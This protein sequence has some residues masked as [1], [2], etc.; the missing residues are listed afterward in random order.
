MANLITQVPIPNTPMVDQ[1]TGVP[2][3][4]WFDF[5]TTIWLRTGG[6]TADAS[7][8]LDNLGSVRGGMLARFATAWAEFEATVANTI[9]VMNPGGGTDVQLKTISQLLNLLG[10]PDAGKI[11]TGHGAADPSWANNVAITPDDFGAVGNG[12]TDDTIA[13]QNM[14]NAAC[15]AGAHVIFPSYKNYKITSE[16]TWKPQISDGYSPPYVPPSDILFIQKRPVL[17]SMNGSKITA[18]AAMTNMFQ[19]VF[20]AINNWLAPFFS[21]VNGGVFNGAGFATNAIY[22]NFCLG[23]EAHDNRIYGVTAGI[24]CTGYGTHNFS[25]NYIRATTCF[26]LTDGGAD[27]LYIHNDLYPQSRAFYM[28]AATGGQLRIFSNSGTNEL[29]STSPG[30]TVYF[31]QID[32]TANTDVLRDVAVIDN[33]VAGFTSFIFARGNTNNLRNFVIAENNALDYGTKQDLSLIDATSSASWTINENHFHPT[34]VN[35]T[36]EVIVMT[37]DV[38]SKIIGNE[39]GYGSASIV[40]NSA[41]HLLFANRTEVASNLFY[42]VG[43][44]ATNTKVVR[45][46]NGSGKVNVHDNTFDQDDTVTFAPNGIVEEGTSN[47]NYFHDNVFNNFN[48]PITIV[49]AATVAENNRGYNPVGVTAAATMGASPTTVTAGAS[50]ETHYVRQSATNTAT[51]SK[52]GQQIATLVGATSYYTVELGPRESYVTTWVTTAPTYTRDV[53]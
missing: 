13:L 49:G 33:G 14:A 8:L 28:T 6:N 5:F 29:G 19:F 46:T 7:I 31:V 32:A 26:D 51:I 39:I 21:I 3:K 34:G 52:G 43:D 41:I 12:I 20:D 17:V 40:G 11:L 1:R 4:A 36:A 23:L 38:R 50:P 44:P 16:I 25:N 22:S 10:T 45:I 9:P 35:T 47:N 30:T 24:K 2:V 48:T 53:H 27:S 42:D 37:N 18:G 15:L